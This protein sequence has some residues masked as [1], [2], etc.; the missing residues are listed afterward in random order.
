MSLDSRRCGKCGTECTGALCGVCG[1]V[2]FSELILTG[3]SGEILRFNID[4]Q[5]GKSLL[6][7][8][9]GESSRYVADTQFSVSRDR[10]TGNWLLSND[11]G[12][13]NPTLVNGA[14]VRESVVLTE[15]S[16]ISVGKPETEIR[17]AFK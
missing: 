8:L 6:R 7:A 17:V 4:T 2:R 5:L 16:V 11:S 15:G 12:A 1:D 9:L 3:V 13:I 10:A 14:P